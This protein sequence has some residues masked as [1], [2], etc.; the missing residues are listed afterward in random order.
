[1]Q[2]GGNMKTFQRDLLFSPCPCILKTW[3]VFVTETR[4]H[5]YNSARRHVLG[6]T[7]HH[8]HRHHYGPEDLKSHTHNDV[9]NS[10]E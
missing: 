2:S 3:G 7:N 9:A 1:M 4:V 6:D 8:H 5:F 10:V